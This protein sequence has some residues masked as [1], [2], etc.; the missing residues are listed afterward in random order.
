L[1]NIVAVLVSF[2][3]INI[4]SIAIKKGCLIIQFFVLNN[5]DGHFYH[6]KMDIEMDIEIALLRV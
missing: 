4:D 3:V 1:Q 6:I 5:G 2:P